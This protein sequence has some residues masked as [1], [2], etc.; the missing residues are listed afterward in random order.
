M[1]FYSFLGSL[2]G[3][4]PSAGDIGEFQTIRR[5]PIRELVGNDSSEY[6]DESPSG[7]YREV[8][9]NFEATARKADDAV[10]RLSRRYG[11]GQK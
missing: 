1:S 10:A 6:D 11:L 3:L 4:S 8:E 7:L 5:D 9:P 2:V